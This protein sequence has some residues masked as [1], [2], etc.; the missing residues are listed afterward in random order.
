MEDGN[1]STAVRLLCSD[2]SLAGSNL[3]TLNKLKEEHPPISS[4]ACPVPLPGSVDTQALQV[5]EQ[6]V[7]KAVRSFP[8]GS[9]G[10][11]D[12]IRPQH[13]L[14]LVTCKESA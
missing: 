11:L 13:L 9:A 3:D 14:E 1:V 8:A 2:E 5:T 7:L 4:S 10:G 12:G 6:E